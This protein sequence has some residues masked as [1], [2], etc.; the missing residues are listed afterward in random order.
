MC[1]TLTAVDRS[2]VRVSSA[3]GGGR[4]MFKV[5]GHDGHDSRCSMISQ[6]ASFMDILNKEVSGTTG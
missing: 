1:E 4:G 6:Q 2:D 5:Q 3:V